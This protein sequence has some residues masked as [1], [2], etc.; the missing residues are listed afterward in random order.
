MITT[1]THAISSLDTFQINVGVDGCPICERQNLMS[2]L[3]FAAKRADAYVWPHR[4]LKRIVELVEGTNGPRDYHRPARQRYE[5]SWLGDRLHL[6]LGKHHNWTIGLQ[7]WG[8]QDYGIFYVD[9]GPFRCHLVL[10][11]G[12]TE[13]EREQRWIEEE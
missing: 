7:V 9:F 6:R 12:L 11:W 3:L 1:H 5:Y 2:R 4:S 10:R 13:G 8:G